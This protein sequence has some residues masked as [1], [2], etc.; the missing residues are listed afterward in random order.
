M[1]DLTFEQRKILSS[2]F[3]NI[4]VL[5]FG[6]AFVTPTVTGL[7]SALVIFKHIIAGIMFLMVSLKVIG[8]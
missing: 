4:S 5:F 8:K 3:S 1:L 7:Y 6:A 2:F